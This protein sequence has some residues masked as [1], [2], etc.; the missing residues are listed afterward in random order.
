MSLSNISPNILEIGG[1]FN[2]TYCKKFGNG[3]NVDILQDPFVDIVHDLRKFPYPFQDNEFDMIYDKF[4]IE[5]LGWRNI[6]KFIGEI[7]RILKSGCKVITVAPDLRKQCEILLSKKELSLIP[8]IQM[9]FGDQNYEDE[10]WQ[11]NA[12]SSS[13][14]SELYEKLFRNAGFRYVNISPTPQWI[15]DIEIVA[16]K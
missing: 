16:I 11:Y 4:V 9:I 7:Y 12:H 6:E 1:G 10:K 14:T 5:H 15:A 13:C 2:P 8:D 3:T